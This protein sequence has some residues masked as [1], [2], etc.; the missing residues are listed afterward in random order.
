NQVR[1]RE[2][3]TIAVLAFP[4][5]VTDGF[6]GAAHHLK[7]ILETGLAKGNADQ[8][9]IVIAIFNDKESW[10]ICGHR[11]ATLTGAANGGPSASDLNQV[12]KREPCTIAVLAFPLQVT[13]GFFGAAHHLK[14][15]LET[16]LAKGNADQSRI[17]IA[18]FN[19]KES[20]CICGHR[21]ATLTGA[22][23]GGP[24]A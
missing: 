9:R 24:S 4:L 16:G 20:W 6:F 22:A 19:D 8:S 3:C 11:L 17:V 1:K 21:L 10:C 5:Q 12:R 15:I 18:I 13:D 14:R 7:R 2:P 23:N